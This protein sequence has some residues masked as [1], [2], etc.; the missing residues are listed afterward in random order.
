MTRTFS[1]GAGLS[2]AERSE[3]WGGGERGKRGA[4]RGRKKEL[5]QT[6]SMLDVRSDLNHFTN[7]FLSGLSK[8]KKPAKKFKRTLT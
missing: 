1:E 3:S 4:E 8:K 2:I 6:E 5:K 7:I